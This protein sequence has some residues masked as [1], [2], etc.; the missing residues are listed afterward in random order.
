MRMTNF[1]KVLELFEYRRGY[2]AAVYL[3]TE[4][5]FFEILLNQTEIRLC[6]P[7]SD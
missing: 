6:L 4:K 1:F 7:F 3:H 2:L 5:S